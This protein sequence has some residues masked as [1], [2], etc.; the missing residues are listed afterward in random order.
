MTAITSR[1]YFTNS[2]TLSFFFRC[3]FDGTPHQCAVRPA[4]TPF[5]GALM[6]SF[7]LDNLAHDRSSGTTLSV[8]GWT[9][10]SICLAS[11]SKASLFWARYSD[12]S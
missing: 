4:L 3:L 10:L 7:V 5:F 2:G 6:P 9:I 11:V 8:V 12:R 1:R